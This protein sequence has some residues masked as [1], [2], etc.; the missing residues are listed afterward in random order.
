LIFSYS[1]PDL[2]TATHIQINE[3][4]PLEW[5]DPKKNKILQDGELFLA[6]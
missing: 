4:L 3:C 5:K 1:F 2:S 6:S